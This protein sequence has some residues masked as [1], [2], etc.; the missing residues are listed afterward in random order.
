MKTIIAATDFSASSINACK[1]AAFLAQ[2]M[3]CRLTIF[4]IFEA[5]LIHSNVGMYGITYNSQRKEST[6]RS[7]KLVYKLAQEFPKIKID[8]FVTAGEFKGQLEEFTSRHLVEAVIIGLK[9]KERISKFIYGTHGIKLAGKINAPV[10]IIPDTYKAHKLNNILV[11]VDNQ[12]KLKKTSMIGFGRFIK[13][14][15]AKPRIIHIHTPAEFLEPSI[16]EI[17]INS[18]KFPIEIIKGK[19]IDGGIKSFCDKNKTDMVVIISRKHSVF[20]NFF[21]ESHTKRVA[22]NSKVPVMSIHE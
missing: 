22:F 18:V 19:D 7:E 5:P 13:Q 4:N 16:E 10:V 8:F 14:T 15:G 12:E 1:Y 9:T 6:V 20:Y 11:A 2:Q 21:S 3:N 17:K